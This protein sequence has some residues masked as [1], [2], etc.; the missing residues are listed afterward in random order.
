M[1]DVDRFMEEARSFVAFARAANAL[2]VHERYHRARAH[3]A[4]L[5]AAAT[6]LPTGHDVE[7]RVD[8]SERPPADVVHIEFGNQDHYFEVFDPYIEG[9]LVIGSLQDDFADI[10]LDLERGL[11]RWN[12]GF[13]KYAV[14]HWRFTFDTH[15]GDH[16]VD[17]L[18]ALQRACASMASE[19]LRFRS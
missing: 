19:G 11:A 9:D 4:A 14:W 5:Y 15:W 13:P 8:D 3:L 12:A 17:A 16:A 6:Q 10:A 7:A 1:T 18:R 2:E